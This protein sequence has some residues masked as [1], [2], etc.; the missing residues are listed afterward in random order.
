MADQHQKGTDQKD[1]GLR[2]NQKPPFGWWFSRFP[3]GGPGYGQGAGG[4]GH[5]A[6]EDQRQNDADT[7]GF[8]HP[9]QGQHSEDETDR[10]PG[11]DP[12][13]TGACPD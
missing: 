2:L 6:Q 10:A 1:H 12:S 5:A 13:V 8:G 3:A 11:P 4:L 7:P 9:A